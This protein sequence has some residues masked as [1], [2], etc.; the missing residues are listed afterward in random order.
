MTEFALSEP[1]GKYK[2]E[3]PLQKTL[4]NSASCIFFSISVQ[5]FLFLPNC[6]LSNCLTSISKDPSLS[7]SIYIYIY[8]YKQDFHIT[9]RDI[10]FGSKS[11]NFKFKTWRLLFGKIWGTLVHHTFIISS[12]KKS[13]WFYTGLRVGGSP[14]RVLTDAL[15]SNILVGE[16]KLQ[17]S[18][19]TS[20]RTNALRKG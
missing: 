12:S 20:F 9:R 5:Q 3:S 14:H 10:E 13:N 6:F 19:H 11:K 18:Y 16:F 2:D 4:F 8:I 17:S 7:L 1:S 15:D